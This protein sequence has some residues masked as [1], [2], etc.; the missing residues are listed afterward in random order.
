MNILLTAA[1]AALVSAA[2]SVLV[3]KLLAVKYLNA[4]DSYIDKTMNDIKKIAE[5]VIDKQR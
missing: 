1:V 3:T 4:V 2:V 5:D